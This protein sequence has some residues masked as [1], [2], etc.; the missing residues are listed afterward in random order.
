MLLEQTSEVLVKK[1]WK[2]NK[3]QEI[4]QK[5]FGMGLAY[6]KTGDLW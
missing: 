1:S 4:T 5:Y 6:K 3:E 2:Q